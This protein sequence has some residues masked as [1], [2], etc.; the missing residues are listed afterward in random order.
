[1]GGQFAV[2]ECLQ[3]VRRERFKGHFTAIKKDCGCALHTQRVGAFAVQEDALLNYFTDVVSLELLDIQADLRCVSFEDR[4]HIKG[5]VPVLLIFINHV[6]H[7]PKL[8]LQS[9]SLRSTRGSKRVH[10]SGHERKLTK[11]YSQLRRAKLSFEILQDGVKHATGWTFEIA[12][13]F[14]RDRRLCT[15]QRMRWFGAARSLVRRARSIG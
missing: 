14:K 2:D 10:M 15:S 5:F 13:L 3:L 9:G 12:K 8:T 4:A 11:D 1:M 7:F 6:V